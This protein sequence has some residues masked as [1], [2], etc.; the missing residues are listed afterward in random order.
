MADRTIVSDEDSVSFPRER[1]GTL[2]ED[3]RIV[4]AGGTGARRLYRQLALGVAVTDALMISLALVG[5]RLIL[6]GAGPVHTA[7]VA[8][9]LLGPGG[10]VALFAGFGLYRLSRL[11]PVEEFRRVIEATILGMGLRIV[12]TAVLA[13]RSK[14]VTSE[15]WLLITS[16]LVLVLV[17]AS[18]QGWHQYMAHLRTKGRLALRTLIVGTNEEAGHIAETLQRKAAGFLPIGLIQTN[19]HWWPGHG[20][21][22]L[23]SLVD[24]SQIIDSA[25]IESV[26]VAS[27]AVRTEQ[28]NGLMRQLRRNRIDVRV[29][30]NLTE[31]L[32]SRLTVQPVGSLLALSIPSAGLSGGKAVLKRSFDLVL[33]FLA[34]LLSGPIWVASAI[35]IETT[36]RGPIL[37][38]QT[39]V[40]K[41]GRTF[42]MYKFRTMVRGAEFLVPDLQ[43]RNA[44]SGP[45]FVL[46]GDPRVT[47]VG[48]FLRRFGIDEFPQLINVLKGDM[49][50]VGPRPPLPNEVA[51]YEDW[52]LDRLQVQPGL[53][54]LWQVGGRQRVGRRNELSFDDH[55]RLDL[56]YIENWSLAY[57]LFILMKTIPAVI[58]QAV[59]NEYG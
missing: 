39:R 31:I 50:L 16:V 44:G 49:S 42:T 34:L 24:L 28:M 23:G 53:T 13:P 3:T 19:G 9:M 45:L 46:P 4:G 7:F 57:D 48:R 29:S 52:H 1:S 41:A 15:I 14:A 17:L 32:A 51:L 56:F 11:T 54:G 35:L 30:A 38:R 27:S 40:G 8:S 2:E 21:P 25:R 12:G 6:H 37:F 47:R 43:H 58:S 26:F 33:G 10:G 18:R 5:A 22:V 36:S 20:L 55:V 59:R